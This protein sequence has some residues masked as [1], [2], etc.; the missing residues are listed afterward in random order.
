M[1]LLNVQHE[2]L[3]VPPEE[4]LPAEAA[5]D[6]LRHVV[7]GCQDGARDKVLVVIDE[8]ADEHL[9]AEEVAVAAR[10]GMM[11]ALEEETH[12]SVIKMQTSICVSQF[13][14]SFSGNKIQ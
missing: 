9:D 7:V 6:V 3:L 8:V 13:L 12:V 5:V 10:A 2:Q 4:L 11:L 1:L 14:L